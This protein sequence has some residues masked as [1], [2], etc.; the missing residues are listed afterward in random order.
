LIS[1]DYIRQLEETLKRNQ[2]LEEENETLKKENE[3]LKKRL[4]FYEN[5]N[6]PPSARQMKKADDKPENTPIPKKR[7]APNGH[8]GATRPTKNPMKL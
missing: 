5:P 1:Q 7:G 8:K 6:T 4:L 2:E 3:A